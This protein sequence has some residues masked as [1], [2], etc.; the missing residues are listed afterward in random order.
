[1][2][3]SVLPARLPNLLVGGSSGIAVGMT[4]NIPPHNLGE[5]CDAI[6][7]LID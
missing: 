2:E 4:T 5:I 7:Y 6:I 1:Q 3:P